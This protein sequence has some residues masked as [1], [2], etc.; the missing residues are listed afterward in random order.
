MVQNTM[1]ASDG[2]LD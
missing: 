2:Q 1:H